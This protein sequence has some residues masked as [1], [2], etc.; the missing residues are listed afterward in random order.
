MKN[1]MTCNTKH[2]KYQP[3][4]DE[5]ACPNCG[6]NADNGFCNTDPTGHEDCE[7]LHEEDWLSC[8]NCPEFSIAG[9]QF[10][11][12]IVKNKNLISCPT[13]KGKGHIKG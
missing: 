2:T 1:Q 7:L 11:A 13:C 8:E 6:A 12:K 5:W 3:I 10:A 9:K 4:D